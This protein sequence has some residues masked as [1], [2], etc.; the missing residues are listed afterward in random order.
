M[1][2]LILNRYPEL[3]FV[4]IQ[5]IFLD[6]N[7]ET[8]CSEDCY[9]VARKYNKEILIME[10]IKGGLL[11]EINMKNSGFAF[12]QSELAKISLS[13]VAN[14]PGVNVILCGM[15]TKEEVIENRQ[16]LFQ[17]PQYDD[18]IYQ[19]IISIFNKKRE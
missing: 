15:K 4:Q 6:W 11:T 10:P 5:V 13:F 17:L 1:L 12:S 2:E 18:K 7:S 9:K 3:D 16:T 14:L 19:S 8:I